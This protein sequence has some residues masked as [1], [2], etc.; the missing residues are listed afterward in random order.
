M[1]L[2][3]SLFDWVLRLGCFILCFALYEPFDISGVVPEV[4]IP[5]QVWQ[6]GCISSSRSD[7]KGVLG[8]FL[9]SNGRLLSRANGCVKC[10]FGR[11]EAVRED[12]EILWKLPCWWLDESRTFLRPWAWLFLLGLWRKP[13]Q[14]MKIVYFNPSHRPSNL[15]WLDSSHHLCFPHQS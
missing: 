8:I 5:F 14:S 9:H 4:Y 11:R 2:L 13:P 12:G 1:C 15:E 6:E 10:S 7:R 3:C